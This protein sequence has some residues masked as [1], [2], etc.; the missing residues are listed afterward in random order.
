MNYVN[1]RAGFR[2][3]KTNLTIRNENLNEIGITV[4]LGFPLRNRTT[5]SLAYEYAIIDTKIGSSV[6]EKYNRI[7]LGFALKDKWFQKTKFY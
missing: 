4:G 7:T 6:K 1:Y 3:E 5:I 2:F